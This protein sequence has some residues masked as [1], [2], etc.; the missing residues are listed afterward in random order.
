MPYFRVELLRSDYPIG[1]LHTFPTTWCNSSI[2]IR[3]AEGNNSIC[4]GSVSGRER[5]SF[6][7]LFCK[8]FRW[9][10]G[11]SKYPASLQT[12]KLVSITL[13]SVMISIEPM[14]YGVVS[15][16]NLQTINKSCAKVD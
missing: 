15:G 14:A 5:S 11:S 10:K 8:L 4:K 6:I 16:E 3:T 9:V 2:P 7:I 13:Q 12:E 1:E